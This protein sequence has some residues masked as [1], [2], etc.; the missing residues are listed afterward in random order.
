MSNSFK[1][2]KNLLE[3][4]KDSLKNDFLNQNR[5]NKSRNSKKQNALQGDLKDKKKGGRNK[6]FVN[7]DDSAQQ[8][9][10]SKKQGLKAVKGRQSNKKLSKQE[11]QEQFSDYQEGLSGVET[12]SSTANVKKKGSQKKKAFSK[13]EVST[14]KNKGAKKV[15]RPTSLKNESAKSQRKHSIKELFF[16]NGVKSS[17][18][19]LDLTGNARIATVN[20]RVRERTLKVDMEKP[21]VGSK[22]EILQPQNTES[23]SLIKEESFGQRGWSKARYHEPKQNKVEERQPVAIVGTKKHS[24]TLTG[25]PFFSYGDL[26]K[27]LFNKLKF[28][29]FDSKLKN[30]KDFFEF[31]SLN[32]FIDLHGYRHVLSLKMSNRLYISQ[33]TLDRTYL[34][35]K[36]EMV[37]LFKL[38]IGDEEVWF[39]DNYQY[40]SKL[41]TSLILEKIYFFNGDVRVHLVA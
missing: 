5:F 8:E 32:Q 13:E 11:V 39:A 20:S 6:P 31:I 21:A 4:E 28:Y 16:L 27:Y 37:T 29:F 38:R 10:L 30:K 19:E 35:L 23:P 36:R 22:S 34:N 40:P 26:N 17:S 1:A 41:F 33:E 24:D 25:I 18:Y 3:D 12:L 15:E 7:L 2:T 9:H 14:L